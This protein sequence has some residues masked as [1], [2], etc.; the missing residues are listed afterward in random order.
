MFFFTHLVKD[1]E[2]VNLISNFS[3]IFESYELFVGVCI[4]KNTLRIVL[5]ELCCTV[6]FF[7]QRIY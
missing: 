4:F 1:F 5:N 3:F 6:P 7:F 2:K